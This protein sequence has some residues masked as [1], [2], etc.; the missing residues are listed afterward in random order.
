MTP[1]LPFEPGGGGGRGREYFLCRR[2][3]ELGH[4]VLNISPVLPSEAHWAQALRDVGVENWV[5]QRPASH[6]REATSAAIDDPAVLVTAAVAPVRALEMRVFW[7]QIR[8]LVERAASEW[9][10]DVVVVGHDMAAAWAQG[11]PVRVPAVLTLHNLTWHWYLSR[12]RRSRGPA[13]VLLRAEALRYRRYLL[14]LLPRYA[15]AI[16]VSTLEADELRQAVRTPVSVIPTGV[17]TSKLHPS[18]E[19]GGPP[20][21]LFTGTLGYPPNSEGI[22]WFADHVWPEIRRRVTDVQLDIV[23][24]NPPAPVIALGKR[25]G[26]NVV[27]PVPLMDPYFAR[28]HVVVVPILTGAGIRVKIVEAMAAGRAIVST[29]LGWEGLPHVTPGR[30][31]LVEDDPLEFALAITHLLGERTLRER[32][33]SDARLLAERHYD[34]RGL[35]DDQE[36][37]LTAVIDRETLGAPA[38]APIRPFRARCQP[39]GHRASNCRAHEQRRP[40]SLAVIRSFSFV[41]RPDSRARDNDWR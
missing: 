7:L 10:P 15:A 21:L 20:R 26:I 28:A 30:H 12:A 27:G 9:Q 29:S 13:A 35:G 5:V 17:D 2:L 19:Q 39:I 18:P 32:I 33:A 6:L 31:L 34:W 16:A 4:Q 3:V 25:E 41:R 11:V 38:T 36:R 23:G 24:R 1:E 14:G 37:V 8:H 22:R 40:T